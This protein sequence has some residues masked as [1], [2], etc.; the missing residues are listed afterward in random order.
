MTEKDEEFEFFKAAFEKYRT[1]FGL[2]DWQIHY[3]YKPLEGLFSCVDTD[4]TARLAIVALNSEVPEEAKEHNDIV[5]HARH[6]AIHLLLAK[7]KEL[8]LDR[9][10]RDGEMSEAV[11]EVVVRLTDI[12]P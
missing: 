7:I 5:Q 1:L 2:S 6:E 10:L 3:E 8:G 4:R 11:E 9:H 12:I